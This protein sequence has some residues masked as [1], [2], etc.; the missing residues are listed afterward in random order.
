ML[1]KD[2]MEYDGG[3]DEQVLSPSCHFVPRVVM[4][5]N[6]SVRMIDFDDETSVQSDAEDGLAIFLAIPFHDRIAQFVSLL[7]SSTAEWKLLVLDETFLE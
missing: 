3:F 7:K 2:R 1:E 6:P 4:S 5:S